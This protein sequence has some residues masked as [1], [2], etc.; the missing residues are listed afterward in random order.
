MGRNPVGRRM[1][2]SGSSRSEQATARAEGPGQ[3]MVT[4]GESRA[5]L[6]AVWRQRRRGS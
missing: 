4:M 2:K 3:A 5:A 6:A 1:R